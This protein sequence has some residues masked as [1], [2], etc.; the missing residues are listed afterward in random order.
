MYHLETL[1]DFALLRHCF[2]ADTQASEVLSHTIDRMIE[3][4]RWVQHADGCTPQL[5]DCTRHVVDQS[6]NDQPCHPADR[7][8]GFRLF[9][10]T[11]LAC[12]HSAAW[13]IFF[14][15][16]AVGPDYQPGHTHADTLTL[17]A[18]LHGQRLLID[19]GVKHYDA[20]PQRSADRATASHNTVE[21]DGLDSSEVWHIFRV[22]RRATPTEVQAQASEQG[23]I[24]SAS[25]TGYDHL[26]GRPRHARQV[27]LQEDCQLIVTDS[28]TGDR[29]HTVQGQWLLEPEWQIEAVN[30][31]WL[32]RTNEQSVR[33]RLDSNQ[34]VDLTIEPAECHF[35]FGHTAATQRLVWR[36]QGSLPLEV[37]TTFNRC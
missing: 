26:P 33:L 2:A 3:F 12:W 4:A 31:C 19:P 13:S 10:D 8:R 1:E 7:P 5:N 36:Y 18:S 25:H 28:I 35:E 17:E 16:G 32:L 20:G 6:S 30:D 27:E 24:A 14:D 11:G 15:C 37:R 23:F 9:A 22:G 34:P 21:I 29:Q